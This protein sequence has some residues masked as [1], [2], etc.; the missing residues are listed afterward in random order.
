M[1]FNISTILFKL[2]VTVLCLII[3][4]L[5]DSKAQEMV[6]LKLEVDKI[7]DILESP[8][9]PTYFS[10][11]MIQGL[12]K[13][14]AAYNRKVQL[15]AYNSEIY[16]ISSCYFDVYKWE[17]GSWQNHYL[18]NNHGYTCGAWP[19][20]YQDQLHFLGGYGFWNNHTDLLSFDPTEGTWSLRTPNNQPTSY[21]TELIG[22]GKESAFLFLGIHHDPR[23][24][25]N[26][27]YEDEGFYLDLASMEWSRLCFEGLLSYSPGKAKFLIQR[28][29]GIDTENFFVFNA[30]DSRNNGMGMV[31]FDK[32]NMEFRFFRRDSPFDFFNYAAWIT[33]KENRIQFVDNFNSIQ[34]LNIDEFW[35]KAEYI[36]KAQ[37]EPLNLSNSFNW[38]K[39]AIISLTIIVAFLLLSY[40]FLRFFPKLSLPFINYFLKSSELKGSNS[41]EI[42]TTDEVTK[43]FHELDS[44][45]GKL[46]DTDELDQVLKI[47]GIKSMDYRKVRR[48]RLILALNELAKEKNGFPLIK[49]KRNNKD[50]RFLQYQIS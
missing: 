21:N 4:V 18:F 44:L 3:M 29:I 12:S 38:T 13:I 43:I 19:F 36:G 8:S 26:N 14:P 37:I 47:D 30:F 7:V 34:E 33:V 24:N 42:E 35:Q 23:L 11:E 9:S 32:R 46:L 6:R 15:L 48:S 39:T 49:R 10:K 5:H 17:G 50:K 1:F 45:K 28:G 20:F 2:Q 41:L 16:A 25:I 22:I 27:V 31:L 40:I